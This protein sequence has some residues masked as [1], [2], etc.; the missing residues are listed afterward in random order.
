VFWAPG[1]RVY[2]KVGSSV[3]DVRVTP[4]VAYWQNRHRGYYVRR[5]YRGFD[6]VAA[7]AYLCATKPGRSLVEL[8]RGNP[9]MGS[10]IFRGFAHGVFGSIP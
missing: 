2:H 5:N 9:A 7:L 6:R 1:A 3:G 10:A 8:L 4:N